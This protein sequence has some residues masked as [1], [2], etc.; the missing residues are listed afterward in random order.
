MWEDQAR[1]VK[2]KGPFPRHEF[3]PRKCQCSLIIRVWRYNIM[4]CFVYMHATSGC[5]KRHTC[6]YWSLNGET[7]WLI[8]WHHVRPIDLVYFDWSVFIWQTNKWKQERHRRTRNIRCRLTDEARGCSH[9]LLWGSFL[10]CELFASRLVGMFPKDAFPL[11]ATRIF[12]TYMRI[13]A[14]CYFHTKNKLFALTVYHHAL[15]CLHIYT[16]N[17][18]L[19]MHIYNYWTLIGETIDKHCCYYYYTKAG[20][21]HGIF[22]STH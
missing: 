18:L 13:I 3:S 14:R 11:D 4:Y 6:N 21:K 7:I 1:V 8:F 16:T 19:K 5:H 20:W 22:I 9:L 12:A 15:L 17:G 10:T 2:N